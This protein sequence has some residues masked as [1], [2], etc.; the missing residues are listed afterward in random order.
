MKVVEDRRLNL[1]KVNKMQSVSKLRTYKQFKSDFGTENY[2]LSHLAQ[3][4]YGILLLRVETG[5]YVGLNVNERICNLCNMNE[6][7]DEIHF[8][9]RCTCYNDLKHLFTRNVIEARS[10][11]SSL[12]DSQKLV[13]LMESHNVNIAKYIVADMNNEN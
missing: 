12:T 10:D 13:Y 3:F 8:L 5:R 4:R 6:T 1:H 7:E 11:F 2:L 9:L